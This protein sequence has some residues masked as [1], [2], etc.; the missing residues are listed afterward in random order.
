[1]GAIEAVQGVSELLCALPVGVYAD[2]IGKSRVCKFA[3]VLALAAPCILVAAILL[4]GTRDDAAPWPA[5]AAA[6]FVCGLAL[7]GAVFGI[8]DG[9]MDALLADSV[10]SGQRSIVYAWRQFASHAGRIGGPLVTILFFSASTDAWLTPEVVCVIVIGLALSLP[11]TVLTLFLTEADADGEFA[12]RSSSSSSLSEKGG[13]PGA[14]E[15]TPLIA[16]AAEDRG[17][18]DGAD[19]EAP[20]R[21]AHLTPFIMFASDLIGA[22]GSGMT[23]KFV[24]LWWKEDLHLSP[25]RV[26]LI[27][28]ISPVASILFGFGSVWASKRIGRVRTCMLS[29]GLGAA[30]L[31][32][33]VYLARAAAPVPVLV[34]VFVLRNAFANSFYPV[35]EAI[36]MDSVP[37]DTRARWK[38]L[39]SISGVGW[40]GSAFL[41]GIIADR[42]DYTA[43][44]AVTA[45]L[46]FVG[47][48][49]VWIPL[50]FIV[51]QFEEQAREDEDDDGEDAEA[52]A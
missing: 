18:A 23:I 9:P 16:D 27:Y 32:L 6:L 39:D 15:A 34:L 10:R 42:Y 26:Q 29:A 44:F 46:Q 4:G 5:N 7:D 24:P 50:L 35:E 2:R 8:F 12:R 21:Y 30:L 19:E 25:V 43:T 52:G 28:L 49:L 1:M 36:L 3:M 33:L 14:S 38:S 11:P 20:H 48:V 13:P 37:P 47:S 17:G 51:P 31:L 41:G 40:S 45:V 22:V